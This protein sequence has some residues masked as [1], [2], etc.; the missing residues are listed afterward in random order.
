METPPD[1]HKQSDR[2]TG[3]LFTLS[4]SVCGSRVRCTFASLQVVLRLCHLVRCCETFRWYSPEEGSALSDP[5]GGDKLIF[6][7]YFF[8]QPSEPCWDWLTA[9]TLMNEWILHSFHPPFLTSVPAGLQRL[10]AELLKVKW[11]PELQL[12]PI[13]IGGGRG[14]IFFSPPAG[15]SKSDRFSFDLGRFSGRTGIAYDTRTPI[16]RLLAALVT[17]DPFPRF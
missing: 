3:A 2:W 10:Q 8:Y 6:F 4:C 9:L 13:S 12:H 15:V 1:Y 16:Q 5:Q 14:R 7:Y 17:A 11:G